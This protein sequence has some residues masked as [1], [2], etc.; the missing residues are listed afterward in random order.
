MLSLL[1]AG[2]QPAVINSAGAF[3][4]FGGLALTF[5]WLAYLYR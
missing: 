3:I 5:G 4:L 2:V 1:Q